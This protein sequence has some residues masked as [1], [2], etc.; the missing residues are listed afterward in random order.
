MAGTLAC[1]GPP[2]VLAYLDGQDLARVHLLVQEFH[3]PAE[4]GRDDI[5]HE[6]QTDLA[7]LEIGLHPLREVARR[8]V[9]PEEADERF[10]RIEPIPPAAFLEAGA[11]RLLGPVEDEW[12]A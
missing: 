5:G 1:S 6:D 10:V 7:S 3:D 11:N 4:L 9:S 12:A 8:D 2:G